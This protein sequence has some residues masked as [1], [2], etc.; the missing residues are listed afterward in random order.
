MRVLVTG[1]AGF[2]GSHIVDAL[3]D[4]G[5][6]VSVVDNLS[7]GD[8]AQVNPGARLV[9]LDI[10]DTDA[11]AEAFASERPEVVSHHAA[12]TNVRHS[13]ADPS[14][15][16]QVNVIGSINVLRQ[17]V[18]HGVSKLIFAS[19][20]AVYS[21]SRHILMDESHPVG[22]QSA[23]GMGKYAAEGYIRLF[24]DIHGL[25]YTI[26]R[27]G[28]VYGIRQNPGGEAGAVAIFTSQL[29]G[30][31]QPTIFGD[32]TKTRDYVSVEDVVDA[33][34]LALGETGDNDVFNLGLGLEVSDFEIFDA[35]RKATDTLSV[36]PIFAAKRPGEAERVGLD[37]TRARERLGWTAE[38]RLEKG[39]R[40]VVDY[41][42]RNRPT[43]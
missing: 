29:L 12:Q 19:S 30:G 27:Y 32:G 38:V 10:T 21:E 18:E 31:V 2:I 9:D 3:I 14:A 34:L 36:A 26:F 1:G 25:R 8:S 17:C 23:Y 15:D 11:L 16:A 28:N 13:M 35:V 20:C 37:C 40:S 41:H 33:N 39:V 6:D 7:K 42:R 24:S 4:E 5:H 43:A 22:P